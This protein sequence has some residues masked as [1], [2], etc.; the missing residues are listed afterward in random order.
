MPAAALRYSAGS[1]RFQ[2][3][4]GVPSIKL[5]TGDSKAGDGSGRANRTPPGRAYAI[6]LLGRLRVMDMLF[7]STLQY[8][9]NA[10]CTFAT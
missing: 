4:T 5:E 10:L 1:L 7:T 8:W 3:R 9:R 2:E 6:G